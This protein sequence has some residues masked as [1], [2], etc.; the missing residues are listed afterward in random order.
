MIQPPFCADRQTLT[1]GLF[2][3]RQH[4]E[5]P[6]ALCPVHDKV[7]GPDLVPVL[8][9]ESD[10]GT[11][12]EPDPGP[13]RLL[14]GYLS[15]FPAPDALH[16]FIVH[17]PAA[18]SKQEWDAAVTI[19]AILR[20]K[21]DDSPGQGPFILSLHQGSA[22]GISGLTEYLTGTTLGETQA[23]CDVADHSAPPFRAQ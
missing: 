17:M 7:V 16:A 22:L 20:G 14:V 10:A 18:V 4:P 19:A 21:I 3:D 2:N 23:R 12:I 9:P 5:G 8:R 6:A 13:F 1:P 11:V 15:P